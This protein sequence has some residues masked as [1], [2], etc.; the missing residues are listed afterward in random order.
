MPVFNLGDANEW[1]TDTL[2]NSGVIISNEDEN[3]VVAFYICNA[4]HTSSGVT[5]GLNDGE[6]W[7]LIGQ[8][9]DSRINGVTGILKSDGEGGLT[10]AAQSDIEALLTV[11]AD[12]IEFAIINSFKY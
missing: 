4:T 1:M 3:L 7:D 8:Y 9:I 11:T 6:K 10:A 2:Y 12:D 5:F